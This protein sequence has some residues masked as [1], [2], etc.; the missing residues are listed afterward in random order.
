[1]VSD[2]LPMGTRALMVCVLLLEGS[3]YQTACACLLVFSVLLRRI[4]FSDQFDHLQDKPSKQDGNL[5]AW[6]FRFQIL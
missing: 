3:W 6:N 4:I 2:V 5:A 1:M